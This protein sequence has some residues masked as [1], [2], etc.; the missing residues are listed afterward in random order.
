MPGNNGLGARLWVPI[1]IMALISVVS[2][3]SNIFL[4]ISRNTLIENHERTMRLIE[5]NVE[6]NIQQDTR[7]V[8][9]EERYIV[10]DGK[11]NEIL[12]ILRN[13]SFELRK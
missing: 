7:I 3:T 1:L 8:K 11:V 6:W 13:H 5:K 2:L 10:L 12:L 9:I 4:V